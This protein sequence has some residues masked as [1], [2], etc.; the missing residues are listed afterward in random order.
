M[1]LIIKSLFN[2]YSLSIKLSI[3]A[4]WIFSLW[5]LTGMPSPGF[6]GRFIPLAWLF[7]AL[8]TWKTEFSFSQIEKFDKW[9]IPN[10][11]SF[12]IGA[13]LWHLHSSLWLIVSAIPIGGLIVWAITSS[14]RIGV[15][16][17]VLPLL[18]LS[19]LTA[20]VNS[21]EVRFAEISVSTIGISS[22]L[23]GQSVLR[24]GDI[25][26]EISHHTPVFPVMIAPGLSLGDWGLRIIP[27]VIALFGVYLIGKVSTPQI[28]VV[29]ALLYPGLSIFGLA[30]TGWLVV[31]LFLVVLLLPD[32]KKWLLVKFFIVL[33]MVALKMRYFGLAIGIVLAEY[34]SLPI[35][36]GRFK[37]PF[38]IAFA[39][40]LILV[41]DRYFLG[42]M[43]FWA[44]YGNID[45]LQL[46]WANVFYRPLETITNLGYSLFD[47]EAGLLFRAPWVIAAV[48][49]LINLKSESP[50]RFK[51]LVIPSIC[52]FL[53]LILWTGSAW[54]GLPAPAG[55][56]F[57]PLL[58]LFTV[59]LFY[60][61]S[62]SST[63]ILIT[64]SIFISAVVLAFSEARY[65]QA[66]GSDSLLNL[67]EVS[68]LFSMVRSSFLPLVIPSLLLVLSILVIR[69]YKKHRESAAIL[70]VVF[71]AFVL[72]SLP[73]DVLQA[74]DMPADIVQGAT[75]YPDVIDASE[76][77]FW[78]GSKERL[79]CMNELGQSILLPDVSSGDT[80]LM[81]LSGNSGILQIGNQHLFIQTPLMQL[82]NAYAFIRNDARI[83]PDFPEN[84][85]IEVFRANLS[86][87]D[88]IENCVWITHFSGAPVY[89]DKLQIR[90]LIENE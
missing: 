48:P 76:R 24:A 58:P 73:G 17:A 15:I 8:L 89:F 64:I 37:I 21:D 88:I 13:W 41:V 9:F 82:P 84:R 5:R 72:V 51:K 43:I 53:V 77:F 90:K 49:G 59:G 83:L 57:V 38:S 4:L 46:V 79:L 6:A 80:L 63:K 61:W 27:A 18:F 60:S 39:G 67:F 7:A 10:V 62:R 42:G 1:I 65:N 54:H 26:G 29:S 68:S 32:D 22:D 44:R 78:P 36:K 2:R 50:V 52:Y 55:R 31:V 19:L 75:Y 56:V 81:W 35:K 85:E 40:L 45:S 30:M 16:R 25:D 74:E 34:I 47:P 87:E 28:A 33:L 12:T 11:L 23:Y 20:E 69:K 14:T 86:N 66:D 70:I 71:T 3:F